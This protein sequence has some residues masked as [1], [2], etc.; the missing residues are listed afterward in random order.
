LKNPVALVI[1]RE[2]VGKTKMEERKMRENNV[3]NKSYTDTALAVAL[4]LQNIL[5][6]GLL[7]GIVW[8]FHEAVYQLNPLGGL[9]R[10]GILQ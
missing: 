3:E 10:G 9:L 5:I 6:L 4:V 2:K 7:C 1:E 8:F